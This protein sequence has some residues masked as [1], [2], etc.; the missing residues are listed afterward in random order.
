MRFVRCTILNRDFNAQVM[1]YFENYFE[2][3][4]FIFK[5]TNILLNHLQLDEIKTFFKKVFF[6]KIIFTINE[7][8]QIRKK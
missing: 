1:R 4:K 6:S 5:I 3:L 2:K 7:F 8:N